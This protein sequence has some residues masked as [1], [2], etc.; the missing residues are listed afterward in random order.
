MLEN[1]SVHQII[2]KIKKRE[3]KIVE[4][5]NFYL[6]RI[7]KF[8]PKLNAIISHIDETKITEEAKLKDENF[9]S[10][11]DKD[12]IYGLP[13]AVKELFDIKN[14]V[15]CYGYKELLKNIPKQNSLLVD[16]YRKNTILIGK[17]NLSEFAVGC[18]T[19]NRVYG[20]T[21]NVYDYSKSA[22]GSSGGAAAAVAANLI[23]FADGTDMMG[24]CRNPAA[25][26]NIYGLRPTPGAIAEDRFEIK[27]LKDFPLI[28]TT[29]C[30]ARTPNDMEFLFNYI[31]GKNVKD[32]LSFDLKDINNKKLSDLKIGWCI[33]LNEQ[34][35]YE[36]GIVDLCENILKK[37]QSNNLSVENLKTEINSGE[38]W[39]SWIT[40]RAKTLYENFLLYNLK[41][42]NE[43]PSQAYWEYEK[44]K[45]IKTNDVLK[46]IEIR[47]KYMDKIQNLFKHYDFLALPSAQLFPFEKNLNN[48]E[49]INNNKIDTY[50]RYMEVYTLSSLLGLPT[51][52][53]PVGFNNKGLPMG[54]QIIANV[55]ED[56]KLINFAKSYEEIFNFSKFKPE[57]TE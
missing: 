11:N 15:T 21:S 2:S 3:I 13:I 37:L 38:L 23:P 40:L 49:F 41:N 32:K 12:D 7:K 17:T 54:M 18:H 46:A 28:S 27:N 50:H 9:N 39:Y 22:G 43:L 25:F 55:K 26:A 57:L 19:T 30:F 29:G 52:S 8:N 48:P 56:N 5:L 34:Y 35:K 45:S 42:F 31:K 4:V 20:A 14:E 6:D 24:S 53:I 16:N 1:F 51:I 47:N 44:G 33:D 10:D 36:D